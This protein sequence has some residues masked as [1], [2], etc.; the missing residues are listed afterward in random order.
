M[1]HFRPRHLQTRLQKLSTFWPIVGVTGMRQV[2]KTTLLEKQIRFHSVASLDHDSTRS[3]AENSAVSFLSKLETPALI[4]EIQKVPKLFDA[5][6]YLVHKNKKPGQYFVTG[7]VSFSEGADIRES[8]TGRIGTCQLFPLTLSEALEMPPPDKPT[9]EIKNGMKPRVSLEDFS[10]AM[11]RGGMPVPMFLRDPSQVET[12]FE[13][14]LNTSVLRDLSRFMG[15]KFEA[16]FAFALLEKIGRALREGELPTSAHFGGSSSRKLNNYLTAF[17]SIFLMR[18]I[19]CHELGTGKDAWLPT[20]SGFA[21]YLMKDTRGEGATLSLARLTVL[22]ELFSVHESIGKP[23]FLRYFK[24]AK[25]TPVDFIFED[26]P[27]RI[28]PL[29]DTSRGPWGH[30]EKSVLGAMKTLKSN[31]GILLAPVDRAH[32]QKAGISILPWMVWS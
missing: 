10:R 6:K 31:R 26:T 13:G 22:N 19:R 4:D 17:E 20:E 30:Y 7:S 9:I 25:G 32:I 27:V 23:F 12:F 16:D 28:V 18:R 15:K 5:L 3:D 1:P 11:I 21:N 24:S 14:W 29:A 2:G 8:L